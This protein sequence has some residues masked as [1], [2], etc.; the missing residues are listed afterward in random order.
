MKTKLLALVIFFL[1][2]VPAFAQS[3]DTAWVRR[4]NGSVNPED[5]AVNANTNNAREGLLL[6]MDNF[7]GRSVRDFLTPDGR[8]DLKAIR[9]SGYQGP[10][11]L[12]GFHVGTDPRT[13]EPV[14]SPNANAKVASSPDDTFWTD[15]FSCVNGLDG[16]CYALC[17]YDG[18]LIA[19]GYF[20]IANCTLATNIASWDGSS[21]SP[22]GSGMNS[23]VN[24]LAVYG[25]KLIAGGMVYHR[26]GGV[27]ANG[28]ASWDGSSWS[29]LGCRGWRMAGS[30][31]WR[32]METS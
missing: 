2:S 25:N 4:Y 10:L 22:L 11:D 14:L 16:D 9:Q 32:S 30:L 20:S 7:K 29:P 24:A 15:K 31:P 23:I 12:K 21:W 26:R 27:S 19:G 3:V 18:K 5:P 13:G 6:P 8:I 28:I 1:C 17:V